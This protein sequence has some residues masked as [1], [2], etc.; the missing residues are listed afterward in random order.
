MKTRT[1][2]FTIGSG[3]YVCKSCGRKTRDD[4]NGDSVSCGLCTQCFEQGG[5]E[6]SMS[7][8]GETPELLAEWETLNKEIES[9]GGKVSRNTWWR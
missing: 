5:I 2:T 7:D 1:T 8:N 3:C 9:K 6:N 4:G